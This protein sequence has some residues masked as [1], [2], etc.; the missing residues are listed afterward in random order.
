MTKSQI[1]WRHIK[2]DSRL[3]HSLG[4]FKAHQLDNYILVP[5]LGASGTIM[6]T[7]RHS[8]VL[9]LDSGYIILRLAIINGTLHSVQTHINKLSRMDYVF[10]R[11]NKPDV[12]DNRFQHYLLVTDLLVSHVAALLEHERT[13]MIS[14]WENICRERQQ[15]SRIYKWA[16]ENF[17]H[18]SSKWLIQSPGHVVRPNGDAYLLSQCSNVTNYT[19]YWSRAYNNTCYSDFPVLL[20][21]DQ[22][23]KYLSLTERRLQRHGSPISCRNIPETTYIADQS[24]T[25]WLLS[26]NGSAAKVNYSTIFLPAFSNSIL[27]I[28]DLNSKLLKFLPEP[29]DTF[30]LLD[31]L[32]R[33]QD[34]LEQL[35]N[36]RATDDDNN[37]ALGIGKIIGSTLS[38]ISSGGS[39][40]IRAVGDALHGGLS[41]LGDLD[42]KVVTS[43]GAATGN[44]ID[45]SGKAF[46]HVS[47]GAGGFFHDVLGGLS[48][49]LLWGALLLLTAFCGYQYVLNRRNCGF[50]EPESPS[51]ITSPSDSDIPKHDVLALEECVDCGLARC[52]SISQSL[53]QATSV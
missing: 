15:L 45:S 3:Y 30:S 31:V 28:G 8:A 9:L 50:K 32:A 24:G 38:G 52:P 49:S 41:G 23:I 34:T 16:I 14:A 17:P 47:R 12:E 5:S 19:I 27:R 2:H 39:H 29:F 7:H 36:I 51:D 13:N 11:Q 53:P 1:V 40:I 18:S 21:S 20:H 35:E 42:E 10:N 26:N 6:S 25:L 48:G 46:E 44:I 22:Q 4:K 43:L 37:I 33:S